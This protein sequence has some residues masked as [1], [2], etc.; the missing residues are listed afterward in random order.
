M[1]TFII[2]NHLQFLDTSNI[3]GSSPPASN[4][5]SNESEEKINQLSQKA[6]K[7]PKFQVLLVNVA[8][9]VIAT[10]SFFH[11]QIV[12]NG[13]IWLYIYGHTVIACYSHSFFVSYLAPICLDQRPVII[14]RSQLFQ[15]SFHRP[16]P[17][18]STIHQ[19]SFR[20]HAFPRLCCLCCLKFCR[21]KTS[22]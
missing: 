22:I 13:Y 8:Y 14:P 21:A 16:S 5:P 3:I 11:S 10:I 12:N 2:I 7:Q 20:C 4:L 9:T 6:G 15:K 18:L 19:V 17:D 1:A